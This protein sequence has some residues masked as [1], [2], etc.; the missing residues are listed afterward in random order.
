MR[1]KTLLLTATLGAAGIA[2]S[3]AQTPVYSQNVVGYVTVQAPAGFSIIA[4]P[5]DNKTGNNLN[6]ILTGVPPGTTV[7][8]YDGATG[9]S[10]SVNFGTWSPDLTL[11]PGEGAFIQ[12]AA[13]AT[14]TFVGEVTLGAASNHQIPAGFSIQASSVPQSDKLENLQFPADLGDTV[15]FYRGGAYVSSVFFGT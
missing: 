15:Y 4:N 5:L 2:S 8:K 7:Y 10:S 12:L 11:A 9:F 14:L 13:P 6:T 3:F 1:T